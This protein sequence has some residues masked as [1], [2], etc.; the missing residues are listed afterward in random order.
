MVINF[1]FLLRSFILYHHLTGIAI[2]ARHP[3]NN[4]LICHISEIYPND[5]LLCI[6]I[7]IKIRIIQ[8]KVII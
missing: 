7:R 1:A 6:F 2:L 4:A 5:Y 3:C 8:F